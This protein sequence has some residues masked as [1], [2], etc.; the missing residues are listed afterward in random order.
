MWKDYLFSI[1]LPGEMTFMGLKSVL[2][3]CLPWFFFF[4]QKGHLYCWQCSVKFTRALLFCGILG[5]LFSAFLS[6]ALFP[7]TKWIQSVLCVI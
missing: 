2:K 7:V 6:T 4:L 3:Q 5:L 1:E